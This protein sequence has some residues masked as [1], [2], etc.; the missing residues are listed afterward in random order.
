MSVAFHGLALFYMYRGFAAAQ[1]LRGLAE[2]GKAMASASI[3]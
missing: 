1:Q 3:G 2:R